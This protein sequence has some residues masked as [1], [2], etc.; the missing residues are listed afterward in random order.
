MAIALT[1]G[2]HVR[3]CGPRNGTGR[4]QQHL[5][6]VAMGKSPLDLANGIG[7]KG[8]HGWS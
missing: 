1:G 4:L 7:G 5:Q 3:H 6:V 2:D 8:Q